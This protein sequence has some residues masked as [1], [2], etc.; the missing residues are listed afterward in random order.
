MSRTI[1]TLCFCALLAG[2]E[3]VP[4]S[5]ALTLRGTVNSGAAT[6]VSTGL[7][8]GGT[9]LA[10]SDLAVVALPAQ[11]ATR[12]DSGLVTVVGEVLRGVPASLDKEAISFSCDLYGQLSVPLGQVAAVVLAP[13]SLDQLANMLTGP[14]GA[15][16]INGERVAGKL[17]FINAEAVGIDTGRR[18]AQVPR[19]RVATVVVTTAA[20][21]G[22]DAHVWFHTVSGDRLLARSVTVSVEGLAI[23]GPL[24]TATVTLVGLSGV[25]SSSSRVQA[26]ERAGSLRAS[27]TDRLGVALALPEVGFPGSYGGLSAQRGV[28]LPARGEIAWRTAGAANLVGWAVAPAFGVDAVARVVCDGKVSWEQTLRP[29][30]PATPFA[31]PV[32]GVTEIVFRCDGVNGALA[33]CT[34]VWCHPTLVK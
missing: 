33:R 9:V 3:P 4:S 25:T 11:P 27:A 6:T 20:P 16:L 10:W 13:I 1:L 22:A 5:L 15:V 30:A 7:S 2:G 8:L 19:A 28:V 24:G 17:M 31:L 23:T 14:S 26:L 32:Q 21:P 18:T 34:V 12:M 29:G